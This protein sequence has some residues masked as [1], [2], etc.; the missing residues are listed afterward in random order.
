MYTQQ[1]LT[2]PALNKDKQATLK[3]QC[4]K[5]IT[6]YIFDLMLFTVATMK[7][8]IQGDQQNILEWKEEF[9]SLNND[10]AINSSKTLLTIIE[11]SGKIIG[12]TTYNYYR[13]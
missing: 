10:D 12:K 3:S 7:N 4:T 9:Q 11:H 6:K 1:L 13:T 2:T 5:T 8:I